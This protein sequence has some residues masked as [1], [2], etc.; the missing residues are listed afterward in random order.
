MNFGELF[1]SLLNLSS[2][3]TTREQQL[4]ELVERYNI[5]LPE[6]KDENERCNAILKHFSSLLEEFLRGKTNKELK[7][8]ASVTKYLFAAVDLKDK[9][10]DKIREELKNFNPNQISHRNKE[11][12][13][14]HVT[15]T[16][17]CIIA[18]VWQHE[19]FNTKSGIQARKLIM[20]ADAKAEKARAK[21]EKDKLKEL[22]KKQKLIKKLTEEVNEVQSQSKKRKKTLTELKDEE[23]PMKKK[24]KKKK[25]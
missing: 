16:F 14:N 1:T 20:D 19:F 9:V 2:D 5:N 21:A 24:K 6:F 18:Y 4:R 15:M 3:Q 13:I 11:E 8:I 7:E 23:D 22:E 10:F 25:E 17:R 12:L